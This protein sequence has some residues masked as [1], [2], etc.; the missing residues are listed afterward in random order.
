PASGPAT[1]AT[2]GPRGATDGSAGRAVSSA[3]CRSGWAPAL[4][5]GARRSAPHHAC[6]A[7]ASAH[8][9]ISASVA[10]GTASMSSGV[11]APRRPES[12]VMRTQTRVATASAPAPPAASI[13]GQR[14]WPRRPPRGPASSAAERVRPLRG[15]GDL[16]EEGDRRRVGGAS[17]RVGHDVLDALG[18]ARSRVEPERHASVLDADDAALG[19]DLR[20]DSRLL[21]IEV[22]AA[23]V[24]ARGPEDLVVREDVGR[25]GAARV[26]D[27]LVALRDGAEVA[28]VRGAAD[29]AAPVGDEVARGARAALREADVVRRL[30]DRG[31]GLHDPEVAAVAAGL[32]E[33]GEPPVE[34]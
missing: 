1:T 29:D 30:G 26:H 27:R 22:Y 8:A 16:R 33:R 5:S 17:L 21:G 19:H 4:C 9:R 24:P 6:D 34:D 31:R 28:P 11:P 20:L 3:P 25:R 13:C 2:W 15:R 23:E 32:V 10:P 14:G 18:A 7:R 12:I